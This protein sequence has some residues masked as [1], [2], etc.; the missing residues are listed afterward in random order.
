MQFKFDALAD[1]K[2]GVITFLRTTPQWLTIEAVLC[3]RPTLSVDACAYV[4]QRATVL[5]LRED[6]TTNGRFPGKPA[7]DRCPYAPLSWGQDPRT[8]REFAGGVVRV[9]CGS[10]PHENFTEINLISA[11]D[12][13]NRLTVID[14]SRQE[15]LCKR[16]KRSKTPNRRGLAT[17]PTMG[18]LIQLSQRLPSW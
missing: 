9:F 14:Q 13:C 6:I 10:D 18:E 11:M 8:P 17:D 1:N 2:T 4:E 5:W 12:V 3:S 15:R 16:I 7:L